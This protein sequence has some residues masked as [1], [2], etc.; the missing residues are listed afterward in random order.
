MHPVCCSYR[1]EH[2]SL[3]H[4]FVSMS[5]SSSSSSLETGDVRRSQNCRDFSIAR[6]LH[7]QHPHPSS[8]VC[9]LPLDLRCSYNAGSTK[10]DS[11]EPA[12]N[13][14]IE[15]CLRSADKQVWREGCLDAETLHDVIRHQGLSQHHCHPHQL[16]Q[17]TLEEPDDY[18]RS[19]STSAA[20]EHR[21][22]TYNDPQRR[23]ETHHVQGP[24]FASLRKQL[25]LQH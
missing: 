10:S 14:V 25:S 13:E 9:V 23:Q 12:E 1:S 20:G 17:S 6:L 15:R 2:Y 16:Q 11:E 5:T 7:T 22:M 8:R 3:E 18:D 19:L 21:Q 4:H 24:C